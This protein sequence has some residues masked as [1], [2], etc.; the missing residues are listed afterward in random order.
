MWVRYD[1]PDGGDYYCH[2]STVL[3]HLGHDI[4]VTAYWLGDGE[5]DDAHTVL[6]NFVGQRIWDPHFPQKSSWNSIGT[7]STDSAG[8]VDSPT[9]QRIRIACSPNPIPCS[10]RTS[11]HFS[12]PGEDRVRLDVYDV[13]GRLVRVLLDGLARP[14]NHMVDWQG[15]NS[16]GEPVPT[17]IYFV[18]LRTAGGY[19]AREQLVL[20]R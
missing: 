6:E 17:G 14:G 13:S 20:V 5:H 7:P 16:R 9:S 18:R 11:V 19:E 3:T 2:T 8:V 15:I 10:G 4:E 1:E 12:L